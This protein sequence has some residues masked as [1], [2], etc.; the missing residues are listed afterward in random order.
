VLNAVVDLSHH[1]IAAEFPAVKAA[2]IL[3]VIHK[4]TQGTQ[5]ED[6]LYAARKADALN[7]GL[8]WGAYHFGTGSD[9][10]TQADHFLSTVNPTEKDLLVL[11]LEANAQGPSMTLTEAVA[12][13][14]HVHDQT[15]RWPGLYAGH[16]LKE[17]LHNA[18][19]P[20][21]ANCW[22]WLSQ[23]GPTP[24][25]PANWKTWTLWQYTDGAQGPPPHDVNGIGRCDRDKFNG[26]TDDLRQLWNA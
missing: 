24:V 25:V 13:V 10:I 23:Y 26:S 4:A 18:T 7:L 20:V 5:Y 14:T 8:W 11:D 19:D 15:S 17:L 12:F 2:G 1:N 9:G 6:P 16:Y 3:G 22:F 21:L